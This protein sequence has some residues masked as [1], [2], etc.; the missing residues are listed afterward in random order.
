MLV[1][2]VTTCYLNGDCI[3]HITSVIK[4]G[5]MHFIY[6]INR[7]ITTK[8]DSTY[9]GYWPT[10]PFVY[11]LWR[12][13][14]LNSWRLDHRADAFPLHHTCRQMNTQLNECHLV[15]FSNT[16]WHV[17]NILKYTCIRN[18]PCDESFTNWTTL[19]YGIIFFIKH[20]ITR[21]MRGILL[22]IK[23]IGNHGTY[24]RNYLI[25]M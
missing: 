25:C 13:L 4:F 14:G 6:Y 17:S 20:D 16:Y 15:E 3:L 19:M 7:S 12:E 24:T 9:L 10:A 5:A 21:Y 11:V 22:C 18:T 2:L 1:V 23:T 8:V